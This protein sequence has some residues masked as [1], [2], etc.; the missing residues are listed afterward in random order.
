MSNEAEVKPIAELSDELRENAC[1]SLRC[2]R[3]PCHL[4]RKAATALE[5]QAERIASLEARLERVGALSD[6]ADKP[7]AWQR[8]EIYTRE[9]KAALGSLGRS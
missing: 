5:S 2:T 6:E 8:G 3:H 7:G 4:F 9:I 1:T